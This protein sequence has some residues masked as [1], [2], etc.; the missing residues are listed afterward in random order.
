MAAYFAI[1]AQGIS[2]AWAEA[3]RESKAIKESIITSG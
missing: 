1:L 3:A 2:L